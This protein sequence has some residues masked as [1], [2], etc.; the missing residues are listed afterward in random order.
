MYVMY[1]ICKSCHAHAVC[2][3]STP[4]AG[5]LF[6]GGQD[7]HLQ[8]VQTCVSHCL[9]ICSRQI[10]IAC[11]A[12]AICVAQQH[13]SVVIAFCQEQ[14][15][16]ALCWVIA[17]LYEQQ[18]FI[19]VF[20]VSQAYWQSVLHSSTGQRGVHSAKNSVAAPCVGSLHSCMN[21]KAS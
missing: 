11:R 13:W 17:Q 12:L 2:N 19:G 20:A 6:C 9:C 14:C 7:V 5:L 10:T 21:S 16:S 18:G 1:I 15:C 3:M 4:L 8:Y